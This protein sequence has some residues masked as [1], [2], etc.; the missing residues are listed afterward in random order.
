[1]VEVAAVLE[2]PL[3]RAE[4]AVLDVAAGPPGPGR[5]WLLGEA[6]G[7]VTGGPDRFTVAQGQYRLTVEVDR[8]DRTIATQGGWWYRGE[9]TLDAEGPDTRLTHRVFNVAGPATRWGVP[10]ANRLF[11]GFDDRTREQFADTVRRIGQR[12]DCRWRLLEPAAD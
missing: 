11:I 3:E 8:S 4:E 6:A 7:R 5:V 12:L 2:I 1:M 10:L 9:Y